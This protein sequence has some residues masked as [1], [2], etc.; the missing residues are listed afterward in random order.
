MGSDEKIDVVELI[1]QAGAFNISLTIYRLDKSE[2]FR[3]SIINQSVFRQRDDTQQQ[4]RPPK[5]M[6]ISFAFGKKKI[7]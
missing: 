1:I 6:E 4:Q 3:R 2:K 7:D 5:T